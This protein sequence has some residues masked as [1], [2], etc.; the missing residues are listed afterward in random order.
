MNLTCFKAY[1]ICGRLG[2]EPN[3]DIAR[4]ISGA[5]GEFLITRRVVVSCDQRLISASPKQALAEGPMD[6]CVDLTDIGLAGTEV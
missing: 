5:C 2:D 1:D 6:A 4:R 3:E